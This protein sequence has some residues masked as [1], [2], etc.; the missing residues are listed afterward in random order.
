MER[1]PLRYGQETVGEL[2]MRPQGLY[3]CCRAEFRLPEGLWCVWAVGEQ[4]QL[5]LGV[6]A[7]AGGVFRLER[8]LSHRQ[9]QQ[10]GT[11]LRGEVCPLGE[12][13]AENWRAPDHPEQVFC[14]PWLQRQ[15]AGGG[16]KTCVVP[17]GR[18]VA[19]P[20]RAD[21][22]FP[23]TR[24]F[25]FASLRTVEGVPSLVFLFDPKERPIFEK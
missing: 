1:V 2:T 22:P 8:Q 12:N 25:C 4:G 7:P 13:A 16:W 5:R 9:W 3:R 14:N 21:R 10:V 6:A 20:Y 11:L 18:R 19:I 23:L 24:L 15:L 17:E